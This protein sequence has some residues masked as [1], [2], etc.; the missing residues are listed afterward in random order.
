MSD[1]QLYEPFEIVEIGVPQT[2]QGV[3][4]QELGKRSADIQDISP[5]DA[6]TEFHFTARIATRALIGLKSY[7]ITSTKGTVV[8]HSSF[9][10][11]SP[12]VNL[13]VSR[14][15]GSLISTETGSTMAYALDNAQLR[16]TLFVGPAVE[17]YMG[18]VI[19]QCSKDE[20][21]ELNPT[22]G[23][24]MSNVRSKSADDAI[25][26]TP[27]REMSLEMCLEYIGDDELVEVT[28]KNLRVRKKYLDPNERKRQKRS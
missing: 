26:L 9:E 28:P 2:F 20:D 19:G 22:K 1:Q 8:I 25:V 10:G 14:D 15:H 13:N 16:G 24:Q 11:Y 6:G 21:L 5:N 3:V 12:M 17:V 27:P 4:M 7:L 23:K 18:M